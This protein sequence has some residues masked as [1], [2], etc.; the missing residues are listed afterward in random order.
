MKALALQNVRM[1]VKVGGRERDSTFAAIQ[2]RNRQ[3]ADLSFSTWRHEAVIARLC[4]RIQQEMVS[5]HLKIWRTHTKSL[6]KL[7]Q[8]RTVSTQI[9]VASVLNKCVTCWTDGVMTYKGHMHC[10]KRVWIKWSKS[11]AAQM[12]QEHNAR[13]ARQHFLRKKGPRVLRKLFS[14]RRKSHHLHQVNRVAAEH[15]IMRTVANTL[16]ALQKWRVYG[17]AIRLRTLHST[18]GFMHFMK[19]KFI[20]WKASLAGSS[21]N[22]NHARTAHASA[23]AHHDPRKLIP[24][25]RNW[26]FTARLATKLRYELDRKRRQMLEKGL[27]KLQ[28]ERDNSKLAQRLDTILTVTITVAIT[29]TLT[30]LPP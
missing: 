7:A 1:E 18:A 11:Y 22:S 23:L 27:S 12:S 26:N 21:V 5:L 24:V 30:S 16:S 14:W 3:Q 29:L 13:R 4:H 15:C 2:H 19:C 9:K 6:S 28:Y 8:A 25:Y 17:T 20:H 10:Q